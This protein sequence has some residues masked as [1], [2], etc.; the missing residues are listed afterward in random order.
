MSTQRVPDQVIDQLRGNLRAAEIQAAE[1]DIQGIVEKGFLS[2]VADIERVIAQGPIVVVPDYL[3]D[4]STGAGEP[5]RPSPMDAAIQRHASPI[6]TIASQL[7][8]R[9]ISPAELTE[10]ALTRIAERDPDLN[11]FQLVMADSARAAARRAEQEIADGHYRGPLHGVPVAVKDLLAIRGTRTTAGSK[12]LADNVT[13]FD[14]A[15]VERLE[16]AGAVI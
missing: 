14:A 15:A 11:A 6:A 10:Q 16:V 9:Q 12:I 13:D 2:R 3:A 8:A 1:S 5:L 4:W 7:R